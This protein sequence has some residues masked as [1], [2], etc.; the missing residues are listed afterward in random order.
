MKACGSRSRPPTC[1][2]APSLTLSSCWS[3]LLSSPSPLSTPSYYSALASDAAAGALLNQLSTA[4]LSAPITLFRPTTPPLL[5]LQ[6][7]PLRLPHC[8][9]SIDTI[10]RTSKTTPTL[11]R[12]R[13]RHALALAPAPPLKCPLRPRV[14]TRAATDMGLQLERARRLL[15]QRSAR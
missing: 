7:P 2:Q 8:S 1:P 11:T 14:A 12:A 6:S 4:Y 10:I 5:P 13:L 15:K 9:A 3:S